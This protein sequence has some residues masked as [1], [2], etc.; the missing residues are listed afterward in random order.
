F[1][2]RARRPKP[3][4][5][6]RAP[7]PSRS[8]EIYRLNVRSLVVSLGLLVPWMLVWQFR[9]AR[10]SVMPMPAEVELFEPPVTPATPPRWLVGSWQLW[11][12][13]GARTLSRLS[14][15]EPCGL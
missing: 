12:R 4:R 11:Q 13:N 3:D 7:P 14:F 10:A 15:T 5:Q 1:R 2:R 6:R 8:G 9:H